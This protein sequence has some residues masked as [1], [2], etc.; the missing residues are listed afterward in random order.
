ML[1]E[2]A[3]LLIKALGQTPVHDGG[4][5]VRSSCPLAKYTHQSGKDNNPSF[6]IFVKEGEHA[7][8]HC[9]TCHSGKL[10]ELIQVLEMHLTGYPQDRAKFAIPQA[11]SIIENEE[12]D[13][14]PLPEFSEFSPNVYG[15]FE[16][17]AAYFLETFPKWNESYDATMYLKSRGMTKQQ[18]VAHDIRYDPERKMIVHPYWTVYGKLAGARGRSIIPDA[19]Y[20]HHDY[21]WNG[22]NNAK[23]CWYN[24]PVL[25][26]GKPL[27]VVEG[28]YDLY[29][30]ERVYPA[31]IANLTAKPSPFK[32]KRLEQCDGA[33]FMLDNDATG[34]VAKK[35]YVEYCDAHMIPCAV[36]DLPKDYDEAGNLIKLDPDKMGS[37]WIKGKLL[38]LGLDL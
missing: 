1:I 34:D 18:A 23:L 20:R 21:T 37:D 28:Q 25:E 32:M 36:V 30:V 14:L 33:I 27:V 26:L 19:K 31:V 35:K 13:V 2:Q 15:E 12:V 6:G 11:R 17:W 24:E 4:D 38:E 7:H 22:V 8:F 3:K 29:A 16:E 9:L 10:N 5:W